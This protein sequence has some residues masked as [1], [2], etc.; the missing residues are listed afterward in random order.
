MRGPLIRLLVVL[1]VLLAGLHTPVLAHDSRSL[2]VDVHHH[3]HE[4]A[5]TSADGKQES[6]GALGGDALHHHHCPL[7]LA[8]ATAEIVAAAL[9]GGAD[10]L[11][12]CSRALSSLATAPPLEPP[13][14]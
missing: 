1:S 6:P 4:S 7:A 2:T 12:G 5:D 3:D 10:F 8:G 9:T 13:L 14:A 11:P